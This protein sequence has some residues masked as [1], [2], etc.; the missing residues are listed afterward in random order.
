MDIIHIIGRLLGLYMLLFFCCICAKQVCTCLWVS[1]PM[2]E[3]TTCLFRALSTKTLTLRLEKKYPQRRNEYFMQKHLPKNMQIFG[4]SLWTL[5]LARPQLDCSP[6]W[7]HRTQSRLP[8]L[9]STTM[10]F[11]V[12]FCSPSQQAP[13]RGR[14]VTMLLCALRRMAPWQR[15]GPGRKTHAKSLQTFQI[16]GWSPPARLLKTPI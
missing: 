10:T 11:S 15:H 3:H 1:L 2:K 12:S 16:P 7:R 4:Q 9:W 14:Q 5:Q 6:P 13:K 8:S